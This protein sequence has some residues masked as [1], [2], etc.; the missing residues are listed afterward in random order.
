[1]D[2]AVSVPGP[3]VI[4]QLTP[5][6]EPS[7]A[8]VSVNACDPPAPRLIVAGLI[9]LRL[10]RVRVTVTD[11]DLVG[12]ALLVAVTVAVAAVTGIAEV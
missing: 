8:T 7:L 9:G 4:L 2:D 1:V 5:E 6:F 3:D 11:P 12:S 10:I